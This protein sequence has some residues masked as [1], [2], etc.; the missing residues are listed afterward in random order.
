MFKFSWEIHSK[1]IPFLV[2]DNI[3][4]QIPFSATALV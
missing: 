2:M 3:V 4:F 1:E